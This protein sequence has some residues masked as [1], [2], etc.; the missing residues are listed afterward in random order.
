[1][2][3]QRHIEKLSTIFDLKIG[4]ALCLDDSIS[5]RVMLIYDRN[6]NQ[7]EFKVLGKGTTIEMNGLITSWL[8]ENMDIN[9]IIIHLNQDE[10]NI[11]NISKPPTC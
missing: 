4:R 2:A 3:T 8:E 11:D 9:D 10:I 7:K 6:K 5:T 1:M